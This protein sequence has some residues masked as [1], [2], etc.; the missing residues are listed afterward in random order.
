MGKQNIGVPVYS[1]QEELNL[2]PMDFDLI[3]VVDVLDI[4]QIK[5]LYFLFSGDKAHR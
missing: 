1:K 3:P 2:L 5:I 4:P